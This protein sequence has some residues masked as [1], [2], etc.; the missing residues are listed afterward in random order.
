MKTCGGATKLERKTVEKN[1]RLYMKSLCFKL[2]SLVP[3]DQYTISK[4]T[5]TQEDQL[6]QATSYIKK[7]RERIERLKKEKEMA[8]SSQRLDTTT[9]R[10]LSSFRL[11][12]IEVR[13]SDSSLEVFIVSGLSKGF[14]FHD[15]LSVLEEEGA[16]AIN[17]S[18]SI[19]G[20][21][22]FC[23]IHSQAI[24]SRIGFEA[25]RVRERLKQLVL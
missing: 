21:K 25:P 17:A 16:E 20:D 19:V 5:L 22:I 8:L 3:K 13:H 15:V 6:D 12:V 4:D 18:F 1:R 11:P 7:L 14:I 2:S 10:V 9:G 24:S 23:S